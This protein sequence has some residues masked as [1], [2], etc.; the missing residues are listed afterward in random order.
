MNNRMLKNLREGKGIKLFVINDAFV[1]NSDIKIN[2][3]V[4]NEIEDC[5]RIRRIFNKS[6]HL[7][8]LN[9]F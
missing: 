3:L 4:E 6:F 2:G 7:F 8:L 9:F 5:N 1:G